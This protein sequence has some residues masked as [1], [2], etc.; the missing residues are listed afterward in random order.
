MVILT[1]LITSHFVSPTTC[2]L[3][4]DPVMI[5]LTLL[6]TV[7]LK[8]LSHPCQPSHHG[9]TCGVKVLYSPVICNPHHTLPNHPSSQGIA[10]IYTVCCL[11]PIGENLDWVSYF[12]F[13]HDTKLC[14]P[15]NTNLAY[16]LKASSHDGIY[17]VQF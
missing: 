17:Q 7:Y 3:A 6:F 14:R 16:T 12:Q 15:E 9:H 4:N 1:L 2:S 13:L 10:G 5:M 11:V 8:K